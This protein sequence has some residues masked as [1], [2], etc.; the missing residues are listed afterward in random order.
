MRGA[1]WV[2]AGLVSWGVGIASA[3]VRA[4]PEQGSGSQAGSAAQTIACDECAKGE[5]ELARLGPTG[6]TLRNYAP[7]M[8]S[9][10]VPLGIEGDSLT[11]LQEAS[12]REHLDERKDLHAAIQALG[13]HS[14]EQ[15]LWISFALC[16][17]ADADCATHLAAALRRVRYIEQGY[18]PG[19]YV[20]PS[21]P[22]GTCDPY[23]GHVRSP[24]FGVGAEYALGLQTSAKPVDGAVWSLG[25][26]A[27]ARLRDRIGIVARI[28][29]SAGRDEARDQ[30]GDGRDDDATGKVVRWTTLIGPSLRF[31]T[32]RDRDM[33]RYWQVDGLV[34]L[35]RDGDRSGL[36][37]GVDISYELVVARVG[38]RALQGFGAAGDERAVLLHSG[39]MFGAGPQFDYGAG[40]GQERKQ[41]G[42]AWAIALDIPLS[43][44]ASHDGY[45]TPGFGLEGLWHLH[46]LF[47]AL[48]HADLV[49]TPNG[50]RERALH[51]AVLAG[52]RVDLHKIHGGA[53]REMFWTLAGGYDFVATSSSAA[54]QSGPIAELSVAWGG[55]ASDGAA[56][57]RLHG[58]F[59][60]SP[61]NDKYG[62]L[63]LSFGME[64]RLDRDRW[65]DRN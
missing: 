3:Q 23:V 11:P 56:Y 32:L 60:V 40:C 5:Q 13:N 63:F 6:D 21:D 39:L 7:Q 64:L 51:Q 65:R 46:P 31:A 37:S 62:A 36:M 4:Q 58:R 10:W 24:K 33:S 41:R 17:S 2:I 8:I 42:S 45:V 34:G 19:D 26:E 52:A 27:R 35:S 18:V 28:D 22:P 50:D 47:D 49:V 55:Q 61:D 20:L 53:L 16:R 9:E 12:V 57:L 54:V 25:L 1:G 30:D 38:V 59:G 29:R 44:Y 43:G 14:P 48:V 15:I